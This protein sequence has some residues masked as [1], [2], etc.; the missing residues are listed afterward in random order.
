MLNITFNI[1]HKLNIIHVYLIKALYMSG[2][3]NFNL[4]PNYEDIPYFK[5]SWKTKEK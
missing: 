1:L 2:F 4:K 5:I 3:I